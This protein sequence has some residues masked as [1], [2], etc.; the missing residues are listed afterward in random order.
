MQVRTI[1]LQSSVDA[2]FERRRDVLIDQMDAV[3]ASR[4]RSGETVSTAQ[5]ISVSPQGSTRILYPGDS[6]C[7]TIIMAVGCDASATTM[8]RI[9]DDD[10][11]P[12]WVGNI[13]RKTLRQYKVLAVRRKPDELRTVLAVTRG[14]TRRGAESVCTHMRSSWS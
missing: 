14:G 5:L 13:V 10:Q 1:R 3:V 6:Q 7:A 9:D 2:E 8:G 11:S 4:S 12:A